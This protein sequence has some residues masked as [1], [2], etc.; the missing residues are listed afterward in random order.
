[1]T[2]LKKDALVLAAT[3][4]SRHLH[5]VHFRE[6]RESKHS[7]TMFRGTALCLTGGKYYW[8]LTDDHGGERKPS[9]CRRCMQRW[10]SNGSHAVAGMSNDYDPG[11]HP[12]PAFGW[13][14]TEPVGHPRDVGREPDSPKDK[15]A[16]DEYARR[17]TRRW[18]RGTRYVRLVEFENGDLTHGVFCGY[19]GG[20]D[21]YEYAAALGPCLKKITIIMAGGGS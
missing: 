21:S 8:E 14:E 3:Y 17:E 18:V 2:E 4:S 16:R 6:W 1:M 20:S 11:N 5:V 15:M 13:K 10:R 12:R 19:T 9:F 7:Q